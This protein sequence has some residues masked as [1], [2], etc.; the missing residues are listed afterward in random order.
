MINRKSNSK[1]FVYCPANHV[2]GGAELLHQLVDKLNNYFIDSYIV[3][4]KKDAIIP[5]EYQKYNIKKA[6]EIEDISENVVVIYEGIF[7]YAFRIKKAQMILWWL[8]VDN[9]F[10]CSSNFLS[11]HDYLKWNPLFASKIFIR[12]IGAFVLKGRNIFNTKSI[13]D[14][15]KLDAVNCY[16]SEYAQ[17]FL[18]NNG[19]RR[20]APLTDYINVDFC[21]NKTEQKRENIVLYNPKKGF[22]YTKKIMKMGSE[23]Q[24]KPLIN[25]SREELFNAFNTSKLYIDFGYHPGKDRIPREAAINGCCIITGQDG[26]AGIFE[27]IPI[28]NIYKYKTC[29]KNLNNIIVEIKTILEQY[30]DHIDK[31]EFYRNK[32]KREAYEFDYQ[33][34]VLFN[35]Q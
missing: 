20:L 26:S 1:I 3:Y 13:A 10:Y 9:F 14:L 21:K 11:I 33:V 12:R 4:S 8:S 22:N 17:N 19:F 32:I 30:N 18:I 35:I 27:D 5:I 31:Y 7:D 28:P 29:R 25:M 24:W 16:Q 15:I 6:N 2:T 23:L 34:K